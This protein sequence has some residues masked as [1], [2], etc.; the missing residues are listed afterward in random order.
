MNAV[1]AWSGGAGIAALLWVSLW[2]RRGTVAVVYGSCAAA[3]L[4]LW[5]DRLEGCACTGWA[6]SARLFPYTS[7]PALTTA[8]LLSLTAPEIVQILGSQLSLSLAFD[9]N[10]TVSFIV[11]IVWCKLYR[12][13][14]HYCINDVLVIY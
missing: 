6:G 14:I 9:T 4:G 12:M 2:Q 7:S 13:F 11:Y 5:E 3:G 8:G 10:D 1:I